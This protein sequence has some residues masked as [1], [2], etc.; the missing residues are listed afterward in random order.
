[1]EFYKSIGKIRYEG[2]QAKTP[3]AFRYY[4]PDEVICGK[5]MRQQLRFAMSYWHTMCAEGVDMFGAGTMEKTY[6]AA[7]PMELAKNKGKISELQAK[8]RE[9]EKQI[10]ELEDTDIIGMVREQGMSMEQFAELSNLLK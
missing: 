1:M 2:K 3:F 6:G 4:N 5:T 8:N 9:L 7:D 10:R